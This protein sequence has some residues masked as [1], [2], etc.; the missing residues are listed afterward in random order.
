LPNLR[1]E[2]VMPSA[3]D[4][5]VDGVL[6][7]SAGV[8]PGPF[9]LNNLPVVTGQGEVRVVTRDLL[10]REQVTTLPYY[11]STRLLRQGLSEESWEIGAIRQ[12]YGSVSDDYGRAV[13]TVQQ[14]RGLSDVM[15]V[16]GRVEALREQQTVVP[17]QAFCSPRSGS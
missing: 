7:R 13:A 16:E 8:P 3:T 15:T 2:A 17:V 6:R 4:I 10:G 14:R 11:A 1:G 5:Y 9:Q 12:N